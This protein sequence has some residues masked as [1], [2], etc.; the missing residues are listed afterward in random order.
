MQG[1][2]NIAKICSLFTDRQIYKSIFFD[3]ATQLPTNPFKLKLF[4]SLI[5]ASTQKRNQESAGS[6]K[7]AQELIPSMSLI[8]DLSHLLSAA[9]HS[10]VGNKYVCT[11]A[12]LAL[13]Y[14]LLLKLTVGGSWRSVKGEPPLIGHSI[15]FIGHALRFAKDKKAFLVWAE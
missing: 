12:G 9:L 7:E 13:L 14:L 5:K 2:A 4:G 11:A 6:R 15:P 8:P 10:S 1:S 3:V